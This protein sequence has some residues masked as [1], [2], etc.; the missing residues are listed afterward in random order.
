MPTA[1]PRFLV[2]LAWII[3]VLGA[4]V[5]L[6]SAPASVDSTAAVAD[7]ASLPMQWRIGL[8]MPPTDPR[9]AT[10][11]PAD[12]VAQHAAPVLAQLSHLRDQGL[13]RD[14]RLDAAQHV[15]TVT[16]AP[17]VTPAALPADPAVGWVDS[18]ESPLPTC[19]VAQSAALAAQLPPPA[20]A[21]DVRTA[22][23]AATDPTVTVYVATGYGNV[24]G[25]ITPNQSVTLHL[26]RDGETV[27]SRTTTSDS[28]GYYYFYPAWQS[29]PRSGYDWYP[30]AWDVVE[31]SAG[32][33]TT[34]HVVADVRFQADPNTDLVS[35]TATPADRL[36][37]WLAHRDGGVGNYCLIEFLDPIALDG[38]A[39]SADFAPQGGFNSAAYS[40]VYAYDADDN[41]TYAYRDSF[42]ISVYDSN[43]YTFGTLV[44]NRPGTL[45]IRRGGT[46][47]ET[48]TFRTDSGGTFS[49]YFTTDLQLGDVLTAAAGGQTVSYTMA[50]LD[51][52]IAVATNQVTGTTGANR[53]VRAYAYNRTYGYLMTDCDYSGGSCLQ[54]QAGGS[55]A[56]TL[57]AAIDLRPGDYAYVYSYDANGNYQYVFVTAPV[58]VADLYFDTVS[59]YWH[60]DAVLTVTVEDS[61]GVVKA[62]ETETPYSDGAFYT[63]TGIDIVPGDVVTVDDGVTS[64]TMTV[65]DLLGGRLSSAGNS[66][67]GPAPNGWLVADIRDYSRETNAWSS[68]CREVTVSGSMYNIALSSYDIGGEDY[69]SVYSSGATG[70]V[71]RIGPRAFGITITTG[72]TSVYGYSET[73]DTDVTIKHE[74]AGSTLQTMNVTTSD[75]AY[76]YVYFTNTI[77]TGDVVRVD[78]DDGN[79]AFV[80]VPNLTAVADGAAQAISGTAVPN[81]PVTAVLRRFLS[82]YGYYS[83]NRTVIAAAGGAYSASYAG[84]TWSY[85]CQ[86]VEL[87]GACVVAV[88]EYHTEDGHEISLPWVAPGAVSADTY[89]DDDTPATASTYSAPQTHTFHTAGDVDWVV[90]TVPADAVGKPYV[91]QTHDLGW[92]MGTHLVLYDTDATTVLASA[93]GYFDNGLGSSLRW[94]PTTA[95]TYYIAV[96]P[97]SSQYAAYCDAVYTLTADVRYDALLPAVI[98]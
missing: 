10:A 75:S 42:R 40:Y 61:L 44:A 85:Q 16:T 11:D 64:R 47:L 52:T 84:L 51:V 6:L 30:Q 43:R 4:V 57:P 27:V 76:F 17:G 20:A 80:V 62:T 96:S 78:T 74:R 93:V 14:F 12:L 25:Q 82:A 90:L 50:V 54:A 34:S 37:V 92:S 65:T 55:G 89:E 71:T 83:W 60:S 73:P 23:R 22:R 88:A 38:G 95:G 77:L 45:T 81:E 32:G 9:G 98:R 46:T 3:G 41:Y 59:G 26:L 36:D 58:L 91:V 94:S 97:P 7:A 1:K 72:A 2:N 39:F 48:V 28:Y 15:I 79:N 5:L 70:D 67:S 18:A 53:P 56:F 19:A 63:Y 66:L 33:K 35:G 31:V 68:I 29:C 49:A 8:T 24:S 69:A 13:V 21:A 87:A 86:P